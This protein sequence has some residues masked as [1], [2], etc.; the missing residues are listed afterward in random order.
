MS[1]QHPEPRVPGAT[2]TNTLCRDISIN[3]WSLMECRGPLK[4]PPGSAWSVKA[5]ESRLKP[6]FCSFLFPGETR[7][8]PGPDLRYSPAG[9][10]L[11]LQRGTGAGCKNFSMSPPCHETRSSSQCRICAFLYTEDVRLHCFKSEN[12]GKGCL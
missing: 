4:D 5:L 3:S 9:R 12:A 2:I 10:V 7:W 6:W 1:L 8:P 11:T